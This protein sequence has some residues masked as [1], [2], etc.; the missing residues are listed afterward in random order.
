MSGRTLVTCLL[1][2]VLLVGAFAYTDAAGDA[3]P[4]WRGLARQG[5]SESA[6]GPTRW[7]SRTN[8]VWKTAIPGVG[9]S[10]PVVTGDAVYLTTAYPRA[11]DSQLAMMADG[12]MLAGILLLALLSIRH[13]VRQCQ[14]LSEGPG[15]A[16]PLVGLVATVLLVVLACGFVLFGQGVFD[17]ARCG[18]RRWIAS[19]MFVAICCVLAGLCVPARS[20]LR[21]VLGLALMA[22]GVVVAVAVPDRSHAY[23]MG[24]LG[25]SGSMMMAVAAVPFLAGAAFLA[26][27]L[28]GPRGGGDPAG[29]AFGRRLGQVLKGGAVLVT[30]TVVVLFV[31]VFFLEFSGMGG[32]VYEPQVPWWIAAVL[33][34]VFVVS[35][36]VR[37]AAGNRFLANVFLVGGATGAVLGLAFWGGEQAIVRLEY[38]AYQLGVP[39]LTPLLGWWA[40]KVFA[41]VCG[42]ALVLF[43]LLPRWRGA[44]RGGALPAVFRVVVLTMAVAYFASGNFLFQNM[45]FV[46]AVLCLDRGTGQVRWTCEAMT[47]PVGQLHKDNSAATPTPAV[48][49]GRVYAYFGSPGLACVSAAGEPLWTCKDLR[50]DSVYGPAVSPVLSGDKVIVLSDS[51]LGSTLAAVDAKTGTVAWRT[52]RGA[53]VHLSG[54]NR[55]PLVTDIDGRTLILVW[56][57]KDTSAY[58]PADGSKV[59]GRA[60]EHVGGDVVS[61]MV[62]DGERLYQVGH[63][64]AR[65]LA[66]DQLAAGQDPVV[67]TRDLGGPNVS[68]PL[69]AKGL[70]FA[71]SDSGTAW[72]LDSKTGETRWRERLKGRFYASPVVIGDRVY[73]T[74]TDG[75][76]TVVACGP[77]FRRMAENDLGERTYASFAPVD[78][79]LFI[80]TEEHLYCI[81]E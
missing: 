51:R 72:C 28:S 53:E 36:V 67:W 1:V 40:V 37:L 31:R 69:V 60:T 5:H 33:G 6:D 34:G 78:G 4:G 80:R 38:L 15:G 75:V 58:D 57:Y 24:I 11:G 48:S 62:T 55:A 61:C 35:L 54:N 22:F 7:S 71:V 56:G 14:R 73:L 42:L 81:R 20:R 66:I 13:V 9:H 18:I 16:R 39:R 17:F 76:T 30:A 10:S 19:S 27:H 47:G 65:A 50:Y 12:V 8:V 77:E 26:L 41:A 29:G 79:Q 2:V 43:L 23:R 49:D 70:V 21:L 52:D 3:W 46:R 25:R 64:G 32:A 68:S 59:W 74:N 44:G 45:R 63:E